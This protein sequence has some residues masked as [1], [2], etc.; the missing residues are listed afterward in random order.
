MRTI[1][2]EASTGYDVVIGEGLLEG[3]GERIAAYA[4]ASS[5]VTFLYLPGNALGAG[6]L[7]IVGQCYGAQEH[8]QAKGYTR[9]LL[10]A[11]YIMVAIIALALGGGAPLWVG[12]Y[13]LSAE[14]SV[15][16]VQLVI[17]HSIA[18]VLWP[19]AFLLPYYF[20]A[21][22][23]AKFT[24]VVAIVTMAACRVGLAYLFVAAMGLG[25]LW[26]WIAMFVDWAVRLVVYIVSFN[27]ERPET[28][29]LP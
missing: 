28:G 3:S 9:K 17:A 1:R 10:V 16:A 24:M 13:S 25:V 12:F 2:I 21:I 18:M 8:A 26:V 5:L 29:P 6:L 23:R 14:A 4:V 20:R 27:K 11:N 22:G 7:T 15:L 19:P